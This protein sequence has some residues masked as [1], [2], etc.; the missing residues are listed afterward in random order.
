MHLRKAGYAALGV[1]I[2]G[3]AIVYG[4]LPASA[5][6]AGPITGLGGKCVDVAAASSANGTKIQLYDCNGTGAQNWTVGNPDNSLRALGKCLDVTAAGTANGT[7]IQLYDCNGTGAQKW[8]ASNGT[9]VNTSSGKCLDA[10]GQSSANGTQLQIWTCSGAANQKWTLPGGTTTP[11]TSPTTS[12]PPSTGVNLDNPAKKEVAMQ[13]VSAAE[14]SS[15]DWRA[16][17]AYIEDIG[18]GRGYT[19]GIIG[20]CS[21]TGDMLELVQAYT[22]TKPSN[23]LAKYLPALRKVNNTDSHAGLD[24][25]FTKDWKTAAAD[26]VFQAAQEA[27]RD[28][29][30]F[31]PSV[32]DGKSDGVRALG[33]FAYYDASVM[34][35][36]DGFRSIRARALQKAKPPSQG[37]NETTWL[38]AFLDER[39][40]EMKK[41]EAHSDTSRV[42]TE[43]RV[44]L[45]NG[46]FDLNTPLHFAVY[47]EQFT[48]N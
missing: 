10:T 12:A 17:F 39:V 27:E 19:A 28:R 35:G 16:Q 3:A 30:Y 47:G 31:N 32:A 34:H 9:L 36:Y 23:I 45:N 5:A 18:D 40:V 25:N 42:D 11:T 29:V 37:G 8:T 33:Q 44:F 2:P 20:F 7:K 46:N 14:N 41:E 24:P 6:T 48:I 1:L 4:L 22:N 15:L 21:G 26:P 13:L 43:Q 38:N